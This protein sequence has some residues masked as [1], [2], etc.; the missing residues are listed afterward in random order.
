VSAC[1][2]E[3]K[4]SPPDPPVAPRVGARAA[5]LRL[6]LEP[7]L[8]RADQLAAGGR[9]LLVEGAGGLLVPVGESWTIADLAGAL[10]LPLLIVARAGLGTVNHTTLTVRAA[11]ELGLEPVGVV[12]NEHGCRPDESWATNAGLIEELAA[13]PVLGRVPE[14]GGPPTA[15]VFERCLDV[16]ALL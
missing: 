5:G 6:E 12:L 9:P 14:L 16:E 13:V 4:D 1:V 2:A 11:R 7:I 15:A 10:G 3:L 8:A